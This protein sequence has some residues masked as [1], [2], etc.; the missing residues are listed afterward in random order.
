MYMVKILIYH[1][2]YRCDE[3]F[4]NMFYLFVCST[5]T[6]HF[7]LFIILKA[8]VSWCNT[9]KSW[10]FVAMCCH[11]AMNI[12]IHFHSFVLH[13]VFKSHCCCDDFKHS[14]NLSSTEILRMFECWNGLHST[15][16]CFS[17]CLHARWETLSSVSGWETC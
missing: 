9:W 3:T 4:A 6:V 10:Y 11:M 12:W 7:F 16:I 2:M 5:S 1:Q 15:S 14:S 8:L 13:W 17:P